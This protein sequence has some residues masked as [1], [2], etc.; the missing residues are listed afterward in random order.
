M[1]DTAGD[2]HRSGSRAARGLLPAHPRAPSGAKL[3][4]NRKAIY[5]YYAPATTGVAQ[6]AKTKLI[7]GLATIGFMVAPLVVDL[8][9]VPCDGYQKA[10][11]RG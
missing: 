7:I 3:G 5:S 6:V 2:D 8:R 4:G 1:R 10:Y 9:H 11:S